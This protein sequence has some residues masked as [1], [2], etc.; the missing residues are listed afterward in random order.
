MERRSKRSST[1]VGSLFRSA[2]KAID[3]AVTV[4]YIYKIGKSIFKEVFNSDKPEASRREQVNP[5]R[6]NRQGPT[7][8]RIRPNF[9]DV[10]MG[11]NYPCEEETEEEIEIIECNES[12]FL[13][14][15]TQ[16]FMNDP[17]IVTKCGHSFEKSAIY[18]WLKTKPMCPVC[19]RSAT[20]DD[21]IPNFG[22]KTI[23]EK[24]KEEL[25]KN[26]QFQGVE[27]SDKI[28]DTFKLV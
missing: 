17:Y 6:D 22:L 1:F 13:C 15:I 12:E 19:K 27:K 26:L 3:T 11:T 9:E 20:V 14:P 5:N 2:T 16:C 21:I 23:L 18:T 7:N 8:D 28:E 4:Y 25:K 24:K 10:N